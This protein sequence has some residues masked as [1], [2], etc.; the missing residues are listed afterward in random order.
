MNTSLNSLL[1]KS[2]LRMT[3][4]MGG[5]ICHE[6]AEADHIYWVSRG[7]VA[8]FTHKAG[9]SVWLGMSDTQLPI[10]LEALQSQR[11]GLTATALGDVEV[12]AV[13]FG[14]A[15]QLFDSQPLARM[16]WLQQLCQHVS[17]TETMLF[18]NANQ[19]PDAIL[20]QLLQALVQ[21][22]KST[23]KTVSGLQVQ[24]LRPLL[25][26]T[27]EKLQRLLHQGAEEGWLRQQQDQIYWQ[28]G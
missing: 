5:V 26:L 13:P 10:G 16:Q 6:G 7:Q 12:M 11:Y 20:K 18:K 27:E 19:P 22:E 3:F 4:S 25:G 21:P 28:A 15:K 24:L 14:L 1:Q 2:Q 9:R 23:S 17:R 8:L